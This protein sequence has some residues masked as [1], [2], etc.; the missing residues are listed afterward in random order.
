[1]RSFTKTKSQPWLLVPCAKTPTGGHKHTNPGRNTPIYR[2]NGN[3]QPG[4]KNGPTTG[5]KVPVILWTIKFW[6]GAYGMVI[7][8]H[9][10]P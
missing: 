6:G 10:G 5:E 1:M 3:P 9:D 8:T 2:I 7:I 4:D